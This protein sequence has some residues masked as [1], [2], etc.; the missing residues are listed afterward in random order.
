[1][2][3]KTRLAVLEAAFHARE[4]DRYSRFFSERYHQPYTEVWQEIE[5]TVARRKAEG[6]PP[7]SPE[8]LQEL[9]ELRQEMDEWEARRERPQQAA[10]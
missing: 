2:S 8:Q 6:D 9:Q 4:L 5:A 3:L 1:M 10:R 7:L